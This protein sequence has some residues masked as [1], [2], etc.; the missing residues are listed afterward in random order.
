MDPAVR[1]D[2]AVRAH[3]APD[4]CRAAPR[5]RRSSSTSRTAR[6]TAPR[7]GD[8]LQHPYFAGHGYAAVRV[9][10][11]GQRRLRRVP[12]R[13]VSEA[14]AGRRARGAR[15]ARRAALVHGRRGD[16]RLLVGRLQRAAD[17]GPAARRSSRPSS[18]CAST[19]DRY[20][21]DCHYMGGCLLASDMLKWSSSMLGYAIQPPDPRVV[22]D[23]WR[24]QWL[25]R[26]ETRSRACARL[27]LAP[28]AR[29]VL[30][31]RLDRRGLL[32]DALPGDGGRRLGRRVRQRRAAH[33]REPRACRGWASSARGA[34]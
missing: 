31:A 3:L 14:G 22:G 8:A 24:E 15:L 1:R 20:L 27:G 26:L 7:C 5:A 18:P 17:R 32:G 28:A 30:A 19:D 6:T 4:R 2:A 10:L 34:T 11:R 29:R 33:A 23:G 25:E 9:D 16:D 13:R 12:A 21:D